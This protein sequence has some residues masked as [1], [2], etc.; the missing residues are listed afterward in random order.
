MQATTVIQYHPENFATEVAKEVLKQL[1]G[2]TPAGTAAINPDDVPDQSAMQA[3][4][5]LRCSPA[6]LA[7]L[8]GKYPEYLKPITEQG[9]AVRYKFAQLHFLKINGLVK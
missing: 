1:S 3:A 6:H 4:K 9:K 5:Y 2:T 8:V 7:T